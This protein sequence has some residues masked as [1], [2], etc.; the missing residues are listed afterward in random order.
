MRVLNET[1]MLL[2]MGY[3][4]LPPPTGLETVVACLWR[5]DGPAR[6]VLPDGCVDIVWTG[7]ELIVAG[8]ATRAVVPR[9][10]SG[11][12]KL[13]VRFRVGAAGAA[14]GLPAEE[15]LDRSPRIA[16][17]LPHGAELSERVAEA[18]DAAARLRL[19]AGFAAAADAPDPLVRA[20]AL[21]L[22]RPRAR[23]AEACRRLGVSERHL[24]RRFGA[25]VGYSPRT[26]ARVLRLQR[27][28]VAARAGGDLA[29]LA[30]DAGF[31]DQPHLTR[32]CSALAGVSPAALLA[33]GAL[34]AG[35]RL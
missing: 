1:A 26:L 28:L 31:A 8:P 30:A 23:V 35:E 17:A 9:V 13:G 18:P 11:E 25:A 6:R 32:E 3:R 4:E 20:A 24:R 15:L 5:S 10:A 19:M 27:F 16:D 33:S 29:W 7:S 34:P 22:A 2:S 21:E 14:L 12:P